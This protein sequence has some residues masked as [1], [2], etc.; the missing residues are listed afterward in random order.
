[1]KKC[2]L[3]F[4]L[5]LLLNSSF[6]QGYKTWNGANG[7][8]W[9]LGTNWLPNG[10]PGPSDTVIINT[11]NACNLDLSCIIAALRATGTGGS[12]LNATGLLKTMTIGNTAA[13]AVPNVFSVASTATLTLGNGGTGIAISTYGPNGTNTSTIAGSLIFGFASV[14]V[15]NNSGQTQTTSVDVTGTITA[16]SVHTGPLLT[17]STIASVRFLNGS[18]LDWARNGGNI[19][20]ADYQDGSTINVHNITNS[21]VAFGSASN[22]NGLVI[23]NCTAQT[24]SGS[25]AILLPTAS[26]AMDSI[27]IVSTGTGTV[28]LA[29]EPNGYSIVQL[30]V[31]GGTLEMGAP[32]TGNGTGTI[33]TDLKVT[34]GTLIGNATFLGDVG[35]IFPVFITVNGYVTVSG[36][37]FNFTDRPLA[38]GFSGAFQLNAKSKVAQTSGTI[39][40][41]NAFSLTPTQ[42]NM[43]GIISQNLELD[44]ITGPIALAIN[45]T[46]GVSLLNNMTLPADLLLQTGYLQLNN[47]T[48]T[49]AYPLFTA[50]ANTKVV[51]NAAGFLKISGM[52]ASSSLV[53]PVAPTTTTYNPLTIAPQAGAIT[54]DYSVRVSTGN[55]PGGIYNT[56][57]TIDRT[58]YITPAANITSGTVNLTFEYAAA[59][60]TSGACNPAANMELGHYI[61]GA[62][63]SWNIDPAGSVL[64]AG[65]Y[66]AGPYAPGSLGSSFVLGNIGAIL[67]FEKNI[68]L[69][70]QKQNNKAHL[71]WTIGNTADIKQTTLERSADGRNF[72]PLAVVNGLTNSFDDDKLMAGLNYYRIKIT[73]LNGKVSYSAIV[74]VL[75][76]ETGFDIVGLMPN[77]ITTS[78]ILNVT[79]AQKT[80]MDV[81][82]TD[83]AGR[84]VQKIT[85]NLIAGSNQFTIDLSKLGAGM[86][87]LNGYTADGVSKVIRFVK[88]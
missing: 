21:A 43:V 32:I 57:R 56:N 58:W 24:V 12:I 28:R 40:A 64:P 75:N 70:A 71:S 29:T 39:T 8:N 51:T 65:T 52:P 50:S 9:S 84:Q 27:R 72:M 55:N 37:T 61:T 53:F 36:G 48:T 31:Q 41:T 7:A 4:S 80:K 82:I 30:E 60:V 16:F 23:W 77:V 73:N 69:A 45:N 18:T 62:P 47:F 83:A 17:N 79:A 26:Y 20:D 42:I 38:V 49:V 44:N 13:S 19:P 10:V 59:D 78:T 54:N 22:Y 11:A 1:M 6:A 14:W 5:V 85:F 34:G 2:L 15:V 68:D 33:Q 3:F 66:I 88:Q 74:A 35:S 63:G 81:L 76:K 67:A 87:Q 46:Q 25:A 86:Y